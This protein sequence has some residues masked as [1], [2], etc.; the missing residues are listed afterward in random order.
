MCRSSAGRPLSATPPFDPM[1]SQAAEPMRA[2]AT[3]C[4]STSAAAAAAPA[5]ATAV[6][7]KGLLAGLFG[8]DSRVKVPLTEPL[9]GVELPEAVV[10]AQPTS[11]MTTLPNGLR[12]ASENTPVRQGG[13]QGGGMAQGAGAQASWG[14]TFQP[15]RPAAR[16][17]AASEHLHACAVPAG[18]LRH[19]GHLCGQRQHL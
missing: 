6:K 11:Q 12:I 14:P 4:L 13:E 18:R 1:L 15:R 9:P 19:P 2:L 16:G 7:S 17:W 8:G 3:R 10:P 5:V